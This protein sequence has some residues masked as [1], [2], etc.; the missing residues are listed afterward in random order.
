M[1]APW[2]QRVPGHHWGY[3][4][5]PPIPVCL[6]TIA[7]R[8]TFFCAYYGTPPW[9]HLQL[10]L[11]DSHF[12]P[13]LIS[14]YKSKQV[15]LS[16]CR[17]TSVQTPLDS[18]L[19]VTRSKLKPFFWKYN[20]WNQKMLNKTKRIERT[21]SEE[22]M[23]VR[24]LKTLHVYSFSIVTPSIHLKTSCPELADVFNPWGGGSWNI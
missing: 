19:P 15:D 2:W 12:Y 13:R 10:T 17:I 16:A 22:G 5:I 18:S 3:F 21:F 11:S 9:S 14:Q 4:E 1:Y 20:S 24:F 23:L 7:C 6:Q 8:V